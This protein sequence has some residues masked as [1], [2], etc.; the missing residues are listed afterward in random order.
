[1]KGVRNKVTDLYVE[2]QCDEPDYFK[3][4]NARIEKLDNI[5]NQNYTARTLDDKEDQKNAS[6]LKSEIDREIKS[7][8]YNVQKQIVNV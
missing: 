1:M 8:L 3:K 2:R 4:V 5:N 7:T 6:K